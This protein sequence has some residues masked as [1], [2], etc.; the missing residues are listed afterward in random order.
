[1]VPNRCAVAFAAIPSD[2]PGRRA[3]Q[4]YPA[5][6]AAFGALRADRD[7]QRPN[8]PTVNEGKY[9]KGI[10]ASFWTA[11]FAPKGTPKA[12]VDKWNAAVIAMNAD[13]ATT[14]LRKKSLEAPSSPPQVSP[15]RPRADRLLKLRSELVARTLGDA[16]HRRLKG[17]AGSRCCFPSRSMETIAPAAPCNFDRKKVAGIIVTPRHVVAKECNCGSATTGG[18]AI[19]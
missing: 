14:E 7:P 12:I 8:L 10:D 16:R 17:I 18:S 13:P 2:A 19:I 6:T 9:L 4:E 11:V 5:R 3:K 15:P 1:M